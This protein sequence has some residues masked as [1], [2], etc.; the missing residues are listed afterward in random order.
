MTLNYPLAVKYLI[1]FLFLLYSFFLHCLFAILR[2]LLPHSVASDY[3]SAIKKDPSTCPQ[4]YL[5]SKADELISYLDI[6]EHIN[7][8]RSRNITVRTICW[9]DS[10]HVAHLLKYREL[11]VKSCQD[12]IEFGLSYFNKQFQ[13]LSKYLFI[14]YYN[15]G[16]I[17]NDCYNYLIYVSLL[18]RC[19]YFVH[20][21]NVN[22][23]Q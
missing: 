17:Y 9:P 7:A 10:P 6:E 11:Y 14:Y 4:L 18:Q 1:L 12:F 3:W 20:C 23:W 2:L 22:C 16:K 21:A 15:S 5:Y 19:S 8:R 13:D